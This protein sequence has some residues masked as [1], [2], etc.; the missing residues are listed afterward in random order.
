[1]RD[2]RVDQ[3]SLQRDRHPASRRELDIRGLANDEPLAISVVLVAGFGNIVGIDEPLA[4]REQAPLLQAAV[5]LGQ[6]S[7]R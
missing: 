3:S 4:V 5:Q 6:F 7:G 1:M 2:L